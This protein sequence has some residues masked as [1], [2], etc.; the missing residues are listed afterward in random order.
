MSCIEG[1]GDLI[2]ICC[3]TQNAA[4]FV[5]LLKIIEGKRGGRMI[6]KEVVIVYI[7]IDYTHMPSPLL[8]LSPLDTIVLNKKK[9]INL[10]AKDHINI[11]SNGK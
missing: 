10:P 2:D 11:S 8:R 3:I 1:K 4:L 9:K 6:I 7:S 5:S